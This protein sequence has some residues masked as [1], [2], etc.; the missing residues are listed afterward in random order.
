MPGARGV[1]PH[2]WGVLT[3]FTQGYMDCTPFRVAKD[4][5]VPSNTVNT[6]LCSERWWGGRH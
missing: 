5:L 4:M 1:D 3:C 6:A 2:N